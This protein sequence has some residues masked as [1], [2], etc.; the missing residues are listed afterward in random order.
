MRAC[1]YTC[2]HACVR[3]CVCSSR[4]KGP[5]G[6]TA[7]CKACLNSA[8]WRG[9]GTKRTATS[10]SLPSVW[11]FLGRARIIYMHNLYPGL[12]IQRDNA[13]QARETTPTPGSWGGCP[14][15]VPVTRDGVLSPCHEQCSDGAAHQA[16]LQ[17]APARPVGPRPALRSLC[18]VPAASRGLAGTLFFPVMLCSK[19]EILKIRICGGDKPGHTGQTTLSLCRPGYFFF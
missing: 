15:C 17:R 16:P 6:C 8:M 7:N 12:C 1:V 11:M 9:F 4:H 13:K 19:G 14:H 10:A 2:V 3:A 18:G 5:G